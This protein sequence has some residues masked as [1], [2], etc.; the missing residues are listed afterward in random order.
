MKLIY[1]AVFTKDD[2]A[3]YVIF[4]DLEG[5]Q[6]FGDTILETYENAKEALS[7]YCL[8]VLED[9]EALPKPTPIEDIEVCSPNFVSFIE[10]STS[11]KD[12]S[13][14]KTLTI[15]SWL[16]DIAIEKDIN[17]SKVLKEALIEQLELN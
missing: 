3:Y 8:S 7:L 10:A 1:P 6:T 14:K 4:P 15:P 11:T 16:N 17:F 9:G 2:D 5:C 12:K 13:I